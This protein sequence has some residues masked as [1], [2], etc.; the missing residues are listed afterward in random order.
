MLLLVNELLTTQQSILF[1][2]NISYPCL[3]SLLMVS[4]KIRYLCLCFNVLVLQLVLLCYGF[5]WII[6]PKRIGFW[7]VKDWVHFVGDPELLYNLKTKFVCI[8]TLYISFPEVLCLFYTWFWHH[9]S[10]SNVCKWHTASRPYKTSNQWIRNTRQTWLAQIWSPT[11]RPLSN[12]YN[13][14]PATGCVG[15]RLYSF[16]TSTSYDDEICHLDGSVHDTLST[17]SS[18]L[19]N[20]YS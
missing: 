12:F 15:H 10:V 3:S 13:A 18:I 1:D 14:K 16:P 8:T 6:F 11:H 7:A 9:T 4:V 19:M 5:I 2:N 17:D 20:V